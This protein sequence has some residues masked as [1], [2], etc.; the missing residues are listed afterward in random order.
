MCS[1]G[2][3]GKGCG[4]WGRAVKEQLQKTERQE[5]DNNQKVVTTLGT[6]EEAPSG[7]RSLYLKPLKNLKE[8]RAIL[9][10]SLWLSEGKGGKNENQSGN[11]CKSRAR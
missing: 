2:A 3:S 9:E 7:E 4:G 11:Y 6:S 8:Q 10:K 5:T 1:W